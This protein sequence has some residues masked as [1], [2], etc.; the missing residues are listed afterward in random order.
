M[1][2][3]I[4]T[5]PACRA[6]RPLPARAVPAR[7]ARRATRSPCAPAASPCTTPAAASCSAPPTVTLHVNVQVA[8]GAFYRA[9]AARGSI[10][11]G[12]AYMAGDWQCDDLVALVRILVRNRELLDGMERGLARLGGWLLRGAHALRRNT[13]RR[14]PAQ[15]R[16][17]LRPRQRLLRA[18]PLRGPDVLLGLLGRRRETRSRRL[19]RASSIASAAS[20]DLGPADHVLEIG[21]GWGGFALHA[22]AHFGAA[23]PPRPSRAE[24]CALARARVAAAGLARSRHRAAAGLPRPARSV[25]Q[26]GLD[27]DDRGNRRR[28]PRG[29]LP[30]S[31]AACCARTAWRCC[32]RSPSRTTATR[33]RC[34]SVD[35]IKRHVFPGSFIPS[36]QAMLSAKT[37]ASDLALV[38]LEDF[39]PPTRARS[40][41]WRQRFLRA[42]AG[43]APPGVR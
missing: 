8:S 33:R 21:T 42:A 37:A 2:E 41:A 35:F 22:A 7:A 10:G 6:A 39:G 12:E 27:R 36:I 11:A 31:S 9:V 16:R 30:G 18:V 25:R 32:R 28:V 20:C 1:N 23:S 29:V 5:L 19:P 38:E 24:Q 40:Q 15:H 43:G 26:A 34:K 13:L 17:A 4:Q 3:L 14:Q